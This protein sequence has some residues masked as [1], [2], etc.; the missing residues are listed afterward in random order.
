MDRLAL[1]ARH[2]PRSS[3]RVGIGTTYPVSTIS[4]STPYSFMCC[5]PQPSLIRLG[6]HRLRRPVR[7]GVW[8]IRSSTR[9]A[10][11]SATSGA[12]NEAHDGA[13]DSRVPRSASVTIESFRAGFARNAVCR[14]LIYPRI[15][16]RKKIEEKKKKT[17]HQLCFR[18]ANVERRQEDA[19]LSTTD[20]R[21]ERLVKLS[22][23][24]EHPYLRPVNAEARRDAV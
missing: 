17:T 18:L 21:L 6:I 8:Y 22:W 14:V 16:G 20:H 19:M 1:Q 10:P 24:L 12:S 4:S 13:G 11:N 15:F 2:Q 23:R 5:S 9:S 7:F 3:S